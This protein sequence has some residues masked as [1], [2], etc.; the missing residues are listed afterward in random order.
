MKVKKRE[1]VERKNQSKKRTG[2][3]QQMKVFVC[4]IFLRFEVK[5]EG[6]KQ[7]QR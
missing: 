1:N 3:K 6:F 4:L 7:F 5:R 2:Q